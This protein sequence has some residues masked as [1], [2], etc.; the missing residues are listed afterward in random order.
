MVDHILSL[1]LLFAWIAGIVVAKGIGSTT[2]AIFFPPWAW[3]LIVEHIMMVQ[4]WLTC[5]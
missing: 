2:V 5:S 1:F 3:Y 4:G